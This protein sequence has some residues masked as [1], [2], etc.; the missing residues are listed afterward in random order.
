M[1]LKLLS[2]PSSIGSDGSLG[3]V[4]AAVPAR[5]TGRL[6]DIAAERSCL[7][8]F[9]VA[10]AIML[11]DPC[12]ILSILSGTLTKANEAA[13]ARKFG[14]ANAKSGENALNGNVEFGKADIMPLDEEGEDESVTA[15]MLAGSK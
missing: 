11:P 2:P 5:I 9:P 4:A 15:A 10:S 1:E 3:P 6:P 8:V 13:L 14:M 7:L 12:M